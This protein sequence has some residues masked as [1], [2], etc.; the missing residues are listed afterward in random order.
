M[1]AASLHEHGQETEVPV[2][3]GRMGDTDIGGRERGRE[4]RI[5]PEL[6]KGELQ[7]MENNGWGGSRP[8]FRNIFFSYF[9]ITNKYFFCFTL[10]IVTLEMCNRFY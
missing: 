8:K 6:G 2:G 7:P 1:V 9:L 3:R 5:L 4:G 10:C